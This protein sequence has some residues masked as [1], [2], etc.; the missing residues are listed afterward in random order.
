MEKM[1]RPDAFEL[2]FM[3]EYDILR[4]RGEELNVSNTGI[5]ML[6][7]VYWRDEYQSFADYTDDKLKFVADLVFSFMRERL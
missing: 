6:I 2:G 7:L 3:D 5:G 1:R 4:H